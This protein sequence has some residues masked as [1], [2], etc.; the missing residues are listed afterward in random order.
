MKHHPFC[1]TLSTSRCGLSEQ[2]KQE[3][4]LERYDSPWCFGNP[5]QCLSPTL[6]CLPLVYRHPTQAAQASTSGSEQQQQQ[7]QAAG[8][9]GA[10]EQAQAFYE[11]FKSGYEHVKSKASAAAGSVGGGEAPSGKRLLQTLAQD[12]KAVLLPAQDITSATRQYT[13]AVAE[14]TYD[15]PTA[16]VLA[17]QQATGW[18]KAWDTMQEKVR[19]TGRGIEA[20]ISGGRVRW[21]GRTWCRLGMCGTPPGVSARGAMAGFSPARCRGQSLAAEPQVAA[22]PLVG[23]SSSCWGAAQGPACSLSQR[24]HMHWLGWRAGC[25]GCLAQPGGMQGTAS[26][27]CNAV[28]MGFKWANDVALCDAWP[29][30]T[31]AWALGAHSGYVEWGRVCTVAGPCLPLDVCPCSYGNGDLRTSEGCVHGTEGGGWGIKAQRRRTNRLTGRAA[32]T[33]AVP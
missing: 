17:K 6:A 23:G 33:H 20:G 5:F 16:L 1:R 32:L 11:S 28:H 30:M 22:A 7:A 8:S 14:A 24:A 31:T 4:R 12:L 9:T 18:Q 27:R 15:G 21:Q 3:V 10:G 2:G 19:E 13:G 29:S 26:R 25:T